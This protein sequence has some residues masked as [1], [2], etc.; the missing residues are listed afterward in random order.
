MT[1]EMPAGR[2]NILW[3]STHDINPHLGCY[4]GIWPGAE[5]ARTPNLDALAAAGVRFDQAFATTP[6]C[7][8]S[9]SALMTGCFPTSIGTHN[10]R[11]KAVPPPEV[12][13]LSEYFRAAGY[14]ATNNAFTDFQ[15]PVPGTAFDDCSSTA[16]WRNRPTEDTPFF[17][18]FHG[19]ATHES[20]IYL[21]DD[22]FDTVTAEL[23]PEQRH[24]ASGTPVPPYHLQNEVFATAWARYHDLISVMDAWAGRLLAELEDDGLAD[25]TIVVFW[26]DHGAGFPRAKRWATEAGLRVPV[27]VRWPGQIAA[28]Q[29][30]TDVVHLA[31]LGPSML[32]MAGLD[33]PAHMQFSPLFD[34][35]GANLTQGDYAF[36]GRDRMD[37]QRDSSRTVRD[38]RYRYIRH[39]HPDRSP[40]QYQHFAEKFPTWKELRRAVNDE[41]RQRAAGVACDVLTPLQR[42]VTAERKPEHELYDLLADPHETVDLAD[43]PAYA[44]T[45]HRL[46]SA[47]DDWLRGT[48]DLGAVDEDELIARWRPAGTLQPTE[49]P[50]CAID[51]DGNITASCA[52]PGAVIGWSRDEPVS[53]PARTFQQT[54]TGDPDDDGQTWHIYTR[55]LVAEHDGPRWFRASRLGFAPSDAVPAPMPP[56]HER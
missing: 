34:S 27:I 55:P 37:E 54:I 30:R 22:E 13:L 25:N 29:A 49:V 16:H 41:A 50:V 44:D 56:G 38:V 42:R 21:D 9:R 24:D 7:G 35:S 5:V 1:A 47:L 8:P 23:P 19:M 28:G 6:V 14:Y 36:G 45:L 46:S 11:S 31:D 53:R 39:R 33:I 20:Q 43:D 32:R 18:L 48:G 4:T 26:S 17:A 51:A 40:F 12:R 2:P 3:I 52:T 10:M 15:V